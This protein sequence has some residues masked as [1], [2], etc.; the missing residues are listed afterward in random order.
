MVYQGKPSAGCANCRKRKIKVRPEQL[1]PPSLR[2]DV[3]SLTVSDHADK[4][5]ASVMK[6]HHLAHSVSTP[7]VNVQGT[8]LASISSFEIRQ[9]LSAGRPNGGISLA[10]LRKPRQPQDLDGYRRYPTT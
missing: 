5:F 1:F 3:T 8:L 9:R 10:M 4:G 2:A 6:L 7:N